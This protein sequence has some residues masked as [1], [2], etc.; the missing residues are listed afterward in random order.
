[1]NKKFKL[2]LGDKLNAKDILIFTLKFFVATSLL[3]IV[4]YSFSSDYYEFVFNISKP[5]VEFFHPNYEVILE[6]ENIIASTVSFINLVPF[7]ALI[8]ATPK[9][10]GK[11]KIKLIIIGCVIL[12]LIQVIYM[13]STLSGRIDIKEKEE[14]AT[15]EFY[16]EIDDL[17]ENLTIQK[18]A[19]IQKEI[20]RLQRM[21]KTKEDLDLMIN[22][23]RNHECEKISDEKVRNI[24]LELVNEYEQK[25]K[26]LWEEKRDNIEE[27]FL[28]RTISGFLGGAGMIIF[29]FILWIVLCYRYFL[30]SSAKMRKSTKIKTPHKNFKNDPINIK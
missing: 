27:S 21:G 9:I 8:F 20:P 1:M 29:P 26:E 11:N 24:C 12:L 10:K 4:F 18:D 3:F 5:I 7:I 28:T 2:N 25:K 13:S 6:K 22:N 17:W 23:I 16:N 19:E 30:E 14:L 15:S